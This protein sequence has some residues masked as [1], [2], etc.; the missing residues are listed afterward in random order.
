M[1]DC[2]SHKS[3]SLDDLPYEL[4]ELM[5][6]LF[7]CHLIHVY[8]NKMQDTRIPNVVNWMEVTLPKK[9]ADIEDIVGNF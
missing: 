5:Q 8:P 1:S 3:L 7:G 2:T 6:Y 4:Y 9:D